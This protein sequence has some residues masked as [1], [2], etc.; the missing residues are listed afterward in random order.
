MS[1]THR[2]RGQVI[3]SL[4]LESFRD[5]NNPTGIDAKNM[6]FSSQT[7]VLRNHT[8]DFEPKKDEE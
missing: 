2:S 3:S 8:T 6:V 1:K 7:I 5:I 4:E